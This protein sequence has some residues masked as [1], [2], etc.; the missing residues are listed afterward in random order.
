MTKQFIQKY[1][2]EYLTVSDNTILEASAILSRNT[3]IFSELAATSL[4]AGLLKYSEENKLDKNSINVVL[5]MGSE[6]KDINSVQKILNIPEA[7]QLTIDN[8]KKIIS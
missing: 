7:I 4:F 1:N 3:E 5:L 8:L 6:L 2:G